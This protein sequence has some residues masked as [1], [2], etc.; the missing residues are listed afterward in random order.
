MTTKKVMKG[1]YVAN[2]TIE[3]E[4]Q[5]GTLGF[6]RFEE[7]KQSMNDGTIDKALKEYI[8]DDLGEYG[9][10]AVERLYT[11]IFVCEVNNETNKSK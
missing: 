8:E 10:A 2:V 11:D 4:C 1:K 5:E 3:F 9:H 6:K 7:I